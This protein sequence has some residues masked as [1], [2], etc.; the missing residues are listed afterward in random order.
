MKRSVIYP[1]SFDPVTNGHLDLIERASV[2]FDKVYVAVA[3]NSSKSPL[4]T[5]DERKALLKEV[6]SEYS[7][8]EIVNFSGLLVDAVSKYNACAVI[9]GLRAVSDFEYELQM[10]LLNR[11]MNNQ[12]ETIFMT[13]NPKYTFVSS[14]I[15]KEIARHGGDITA[16]APHV[17]VDALA[18]KKD[19]GL[20]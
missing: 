11:E 5:I 17:L 18:K 3:I 10:A 16:Y 2:I 9:K 7:N 13:P 6:C 12:C 15:I 20:L 8:V 19:E 1:G 4:F 14:T